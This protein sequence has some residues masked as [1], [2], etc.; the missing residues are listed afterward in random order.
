VLIGPAEKF[1]VILLEK[2]QRLR[3]FAKLTPHLASRTMHFDASLSTIDGPFRKASRAMRKTTRRRPEVEALESM[4]LLS[5][6]SGAVHEAAATVPNPM[7]LSGTLKGT[8]VPQGPT[9]GLLEKGSGTFNKP[10][11]KV[12][13]P[14][15]TISVTGTPQNL[16]I[17]GKAGS[18]NLKV[19]LT[20]TAATGVSGTYQ[21]LGGTGSLASETG[22]GT[23]TVSYTGTKF[24]AHFS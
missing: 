22:S 18:L 7:H 16:T 8:F 1:F 2:E 19:E 6:V 9:S 15:T 11:G 12:S 4:T 5:G 24:T 23:V 17:R 13:L 3:Y 10:F 21:I 20:S 14:T